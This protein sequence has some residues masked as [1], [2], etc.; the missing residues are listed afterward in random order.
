MALSE[1]DV[2]IRDQ[3]IWSSDAGMIAEG[4]AGE[5]FLQK[6]G[7]K[8]KP[9][10]DDVE[11]VQMGLAMQEPIMRIAAGRWGWEFKDADYT[12]HHPKHNWLASHF[13]YISSDGKTLYEVKNLGVHQRKKYGDDGTEMISEK[14][15][16]QC[17][18]EQIVHEGVQN[19]ILVVLFGGQEL[20]HYP[21][22][23]TALEGEAHIR[24]M[25]EFWAQVQTKS[26]NPQT[27]A[28]VVGDVYKVDD[29]ESMV[30]NAALETA[31]NQLAMIKEKLK[32]YE[33]AE[34]GLKQ[35]IQSAMGPKAQ[36][37][38][39]DGS[40]LC[41]WKTSK[42]SKRFSADLLKQALPDTYEKFVVEQPGSRRFL[43][44]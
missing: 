22:N 7:Q 29:G 32:E 9:N 3:H 42:P 4:K 27:M 43:V 33:E 31:C 6:T 44:K 15:R 8:P 28:D 20:C 36:L 30:A 23:F 12:L 41:T 39:F 18:H 25:A 16:A 35:M 11:A 14:Y 24:A 1:H 5:V 26:Y 13:D 34:E 17:L 21:Q 38:A 19:I 10:L 2:A 37:K 40:V